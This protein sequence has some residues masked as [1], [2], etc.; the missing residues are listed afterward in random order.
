MKTI[1]LKD[2]RKGDLFMLP[3]GRCV[4]VKQ[5]YIRE[6]GKYSVSKYDDYNY[7]RLLLGNTKVVV[8]FEY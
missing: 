3:K 6:C 4:Y 1:L 7:E 8:D 2:L 5:M